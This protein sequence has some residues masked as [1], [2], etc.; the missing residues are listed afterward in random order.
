[1]Y[2]SINFSMLNASIIMNL[3]SF[4]MR[5]YFTPISSCI[6]RYRP[7]LIPWTKSTLDRIA[8]ILISKSL[9]SFNISWIKIRNI[10][11]WRIWNISYMMRKYWLR[12]IRRIMG[13]RRW[14]RGIWIKF[15]Q[16]SILCL[17]FYILSIDLW[18]N[19]SGYCSR[20][21]FIFFKIFYLLILKFKIR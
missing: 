17:Q 12:N 6:T 19:I 7:E 9:N 15:L 18:G 14:R 4:C 2:W 5:N 3:I 16:R 20:R 13:R 1:M 10:W 11:I 8:N 21:S